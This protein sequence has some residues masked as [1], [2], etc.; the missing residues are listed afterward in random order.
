MEENKTSCG[1][2]NLNQEVK[3]ETLNEEKIGLEAEETQ[4]EQGNDN[5]KSTEN[6]QT[7]ENE[8]PKQ[9]YYYPY[10]QPVYIPKPTFEKE[11]FEKTAVRKTANK[12][13][14]CLILFN[15][16]SLVL[17]AVVAGILSFLGKINYLS[18]PFF[19]LEFNIILSLFGFL[20]VGAIIFMVEKGKNNLSFD[21]PK[22]KSFISLILMGVGFFYAANVLIV[23]LQSNLS[24]LGE[25]KGGEIALPTGVTGALM[26][27][28]AVAVAPALLEEFVFRGAILG[29]LLKYGKA[30]AIFTSALLFG[31]MHGN[32]VQI[33]FAFLA[34]LIIGFVVVETGSFWSGVLIHFINN[35]MSVGLDYL[36][37]YL[38]DEKTNSLYMLLLVVLIS[39]GL[40]GYFAYTIK[41]KDAFVLSKS[42]HISTSYE[43]VKWFIS[44]GAM[45]IYIIII[46]AQVIIL[47]IS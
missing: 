15:L 35:L 18:D 14:L 17:Q 29:G 33:P 8:S 24:F 23:M 28:L 31:L 22:R 7:V 40:I 16:I 41:N 47:Q 30:F 27:V 1:E 3:K 43:R 45:V 36:K 2:N 37:N 12:I 21:L 20:P 25:L 26:S 6:K 4:K 5:T 9:G 32:L 19:L 38:G 42:Q 10:K 11:Y 46:A 34:G 13:G 44:A 39:I